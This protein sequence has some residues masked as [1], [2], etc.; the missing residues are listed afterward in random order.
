MN[1]WMKKE[2]L[3]LQ[4]NLSQKICPQGKFVPGNFPETDF[5]GMKFPRGQKV[6]S[7]TTFPRRWNFPGDEFSPG[8]NF[9]GRIFLEP[10]LTLVAS[11]MNSYK[12]GSSLPQCPSDSSHNQSTP[13]LFTAWWERGS[14]PT[15]PHSAASDNGSFHVQQLK[16]NEE[17]SLSNRQQPESLLDKCHK[18]GD[19]NWGYLGWGG[20]RQ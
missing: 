8:T 2:A 13:S 4:E 11:S 14:T 1:V 6:S 17:G 12:G 7:S 16:R 20:A 10:V 3:R 15:A 9:P 5:P 18:H 19:K